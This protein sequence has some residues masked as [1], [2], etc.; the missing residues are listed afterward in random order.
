[1]L[2]AWQANRKAVVNSAELR[3]S[4]SVWPTEVMRQNSTNHLH[5]KKDQGWEF[6]G[7]LKVYTETYMPDSLPNFT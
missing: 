4:Q 5:Q 7:G 1:M 2:V 6:E 3:K